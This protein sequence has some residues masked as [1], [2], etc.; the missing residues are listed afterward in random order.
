LWSRTDTLHIPASDMPNI[1]AVLTE[2][3]LSEVRSRIG[4]SQYGS[5]DAN[6]VARAPGDAERSVPLLAGQFGK[7][8]H[9]LRGHALLDAYEAQGRGTVPLLAVDWGQVGI[10]LVRKS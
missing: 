9:G 10:L 6:I 7:E 8:F 5:E 4:E 2:T 1:R 3:P